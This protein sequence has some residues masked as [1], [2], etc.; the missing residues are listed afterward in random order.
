MKQ[1]FDYLAN[2][3][4]ELAKGRQIYYHPNPGNLGD[5]LINIGVEKF[6]YDYD[7]HA[8]LILPED[9]VNSLTQKK[10]LISESNIDNINTKDSILLWGGGGGWC[11]NWMGGFENVAR[12]SKKFRHT[13]VLPSTYAIPVKIPNVTFFARDQYQSQE[14]VSESLFCHDMAFYI[15]RFERTIPVTAEKG[16]C[17]RRDKESGFEKR[18]RIPLA[19][20][21]VSWMGN[22][23]SPVEPMIEH[24][25]KYKEIHTD[26]LHVAI[27]CCLLGTPVYL[28]PGSY[29]KNRAV[30][31]TSMQGRFPGAKWRTKIPFPDFIRNSFERRILRARRKIGD[32]IRNSSS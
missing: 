1:E 6:L 20:V 24:L 12:L 22:Y 28:Y 27:A 16:F 23:L 8:R 2:K 10:D 9:N 31:L 18:W 29:F 21:D 17:F 30:Y 26:R 7:I 11:N 19:N 25:Q 4:K 3:I 15:G 13:I 14:F 32:I 5:A